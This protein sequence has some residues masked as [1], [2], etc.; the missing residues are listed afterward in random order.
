MF[1]KQTI[2]D[3]LSNIEGD[4]EI[5][6]VL[7]GAW[8]L[9]PL[10]QHERLT[11]V[12]LNK[13][14]GQRAATNL[15]AKLSTAKY[16]MKVDAH[17]AF[18]KGFDVK[19]MSDMQ[20]DWT[21][22]PVMRNLHVFDWV[23]PQGHRR[24][25][26][27]SGPC[28]ECGAET[29]RDIVWIPKASPQS[30]SYRFDR[31]LHFQY[32]NQ[33]K[34]KQQGDLVD[35]MSLQG[36]AFLLTRKKYWELDICDETWGSWG[37]QGSEVA[38]KTWL[39][40]GR[41]VCN[42]R[43]WYAHLFRTQGGDFSFPYPQSEKAI[44]QTRQISREIFLNDKWPKAT[45][46]LQWL[47]DKFQPPDWAPVTKGIIYYTD[48]KLNMKIARKVRKQLLKMNLPIVSASLKP[49]DFGKNIHLDQK[50][51]YLTMFKQ[52]LAALE[53]SESDV[54]FFCEHDVLYHP[55]HFQF[56]PPKK[57]VY[58]YNTNVYKLRQ[59]GLAIKVDNCKQTSGLCA[60]KDLLIR[61]YQERI[62]RVEESGFSRKMGFEPGTHRRPERVD[63][64]VAESWQ[65]EY[66]N[67]DIR[68][69]TNLTPSRWTKEEFRNQGYT[70][71]WTETYEIPGWGSTTQL[72]EK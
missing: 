69:N 44:E 52:I 26:G 56:T 4:T 40:G 31:T 17:C 33:Y 7:D 22:V 43:T 67:V 37:N 9:E 68:H 30:T 47:I 59:D 3:I 71:G 10:P 72:I 28:K 46:K 53:N 12:Y 34:D 39:S 23:C 24:Y 18:D 64:Y 57:D 54:I 14:I 32:W 6:V 1:L 27:P 19:L 38:L 20:D 65:S 16:V 41:V 42:K 36:S 11:V 58:Y 5:I 13:S 55:T 63:D 25:Q 45:H 35:T 51:G 62:R 60:Y 15:A 21:M 48:N 66:P 29:T 50:R 61:H 8:P 2:E 70:Q 49:M